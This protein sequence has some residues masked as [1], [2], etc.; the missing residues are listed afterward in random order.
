VAAPSVYFRFCA[1]K[2][3]LERNVIFWIV[4]LGSS[5]EVHWRF[6]GTYRLHLQGRRVSQTRNQQ[7]AGD[8]QTRC[9]DNSSIMMMVTICSSETSVD[10]TSVQPIVTAVGTSNAKLLPLSVCDFL[11]SDI[12][13][14]T[15]VCLC[16]GFLLDGYFVWSVTRN[17]HL[18]DGRNVLGWCISSCG[19]CLRRRF[20]QQ[21]FHVG[22]V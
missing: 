13:L 7:E 3:T 15:N 17:L 6:G 2:T 11:L 21:E 4:T 19:F 16:L 1:I 10:C 5:E 12:A 8:K 14:L 18:S 22:Y 20:P 9:L